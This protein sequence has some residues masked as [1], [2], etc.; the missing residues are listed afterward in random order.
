MY[1]GNKNTEDINTLMNLLK[2]LNKDYIQLSDKTKRYRAWCSLLQH[3]RNRDIKR[4]LTRLRILVGEKIYLKSKASRKKNYAD[5][6]NY[7]STE[8]IIIY[9]AIYGNYDRIRD[10]GIVPDNCKFIIYTDN[11]YTNSSIWERREYHSKYFDA[12]SDLEK[13]RFIKMHPHLLFPESEYSVYLD[14]SIWIISD[15]TELVNYIPKEGFAFHIHSSRNCIYDEL[16]AAYIYKKID[17]NE[18]NKFK[19]FIT[20]SNMPTA[21]GML[22]CGIIARKHHELLCIKIMNEWWDM[23]ERYIKRDQ[24]SLPYILFKNGIS[25]DEVGTLGNDIYH[26]YSFRINEHT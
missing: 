18:F 7:F 21:Y 14:G 22:E 25:V 23:F 17:K 11:M 3:L 16:R 4:I 15:L 19:K 26:N 8:K 2:N 13:N 1:S 5:I 6:P 12:L 24:I 20:E 10:P 9:T